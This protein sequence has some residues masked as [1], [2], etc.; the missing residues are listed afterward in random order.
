MLSVEGIDVSYGS[1]KALKEISFHVPPKGI[2]AL[3]GANGA[4]KT[5]TLR[6]VCGMMKPA[7]G[8]ITLDGERI[9]GL[10]TEEIVKRGVSM[11]A[12]GRRLF[13]EMTV[14]ENLEVG[15]FNRKDRAEVKRD[16]KNIYEIFGRLEERKSQLAASLSGGEQ[17][18]LAIGRALMSRPKLLLLD[19]PSLGLAPILV[20]DI[21]KIIKDLNDGGLTILLVEQNAR[22]ALQYAKEAYVLEIGRIILNGDPKSLLSNKQFYDAYLGSLA[23]QR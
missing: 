9:D 10:V 2:I 23:M 15:A 6:T 18:M 20:R 11:V 8:T 3:L 7:K 21:F 5:T 14:L 12:E 22:K 19:E 4:G 13:P 1:V 17:Q 16:L